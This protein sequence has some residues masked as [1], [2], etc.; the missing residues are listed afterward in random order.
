MSYVFVEV[1]KHGRDHILTYDHY[2]WYS[3]LLKYFNIEVKPKRVQF[4]GECT[5]WRY[6][7]SHK[8]CDTFTCSWLCDEEARLKYEGKIK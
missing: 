5:I 7:P 1:K 2:P 3:I 6:L 4:I 8:S